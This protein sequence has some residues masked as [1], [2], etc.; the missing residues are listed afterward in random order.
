MGAGMCIGMGTPCCH[1]AALGACPPGCV[2]WL[3]RGC[4]GFGISFFGWVWRGLGVAWM[5]GVGQGGQ[6]KFQKCSTV[7]VRASRARR[8]NHFQKV[9]DT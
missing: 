2:A 7:G 9:S 6:A 8:A 4:W 1:K 3:G 5:V